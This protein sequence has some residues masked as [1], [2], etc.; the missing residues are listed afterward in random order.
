MELYGDDA[1]DAVTEYVGV[2]VTRVV[3]LDH[4]ATPQEKGEKTL[5]TKRDGEMQEVSLQRVGAVG[6]CTVNIRN[7][8]GVKRSEIEED[9]AN[10]LRLNQAQI[11]QAKAAKTMKSKNSR[12]KHL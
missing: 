11:K 9:G 8:K 2:T 4:G 1:V 3:E 10:I 12:G 5:V 7:S 6:G